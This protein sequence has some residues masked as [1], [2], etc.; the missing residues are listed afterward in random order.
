MVIPIKVKGSIPTI[1]YRLFKVL[2]TEGEHSKLSSD[3]LKK[4]LELHGWI[5]VYYYVNIN[6]VLY[7]VDGNG[8]HTFCMAN[9]V[10]NLNGSYDFPAIE[11]DI[12]DIPE[13]EKLTKAKQLLLELEAKRNKWIDRQVFD[14]F[15]IDLDFS[16]DDMLHFVP[17]EIEEIKLTDDELDKFFLEDNDQTTTVT[18]FKMVFCFE[19]KVFNIIESKIKESGLPKEQF[20]I[21]AIGI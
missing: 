10:K 20:L 13:K 4:S 16:F 14:D 7:T 21:E 18:E 3:E 12:S 1:D 15:S 6:D 5:S 2:K 8:R 9:N 19:E 11:I 17:T